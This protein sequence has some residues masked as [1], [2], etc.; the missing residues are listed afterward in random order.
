M[1]FMRFCENDSCRVVCYRA[2]SFGEC[3]LCWTIGRRVTDETTL[4]EIL[5]A[6]YDRPHFEQLRLE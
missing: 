1:I 4:D 3:P 2:A 6:L 5:C